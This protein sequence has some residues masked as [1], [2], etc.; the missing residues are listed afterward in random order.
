MIRV[1]REQS[2]VGI[3]DRS[4]C[5]PGRAVVDRVEPGSVGGIGR[6]DRDAQS[7][8]AVDVG[9]V[10]HLTGRSGEVN[11]LRNQRPHGSDR[12]TGVF[13]NGGKNRSCRIIQ[14]RR[15]IDVDDRNVGCLGRRT[16]GRGPA[17]GRGIDFRAGRSGRLIP[18]VEI[19]TGRRAADAIG[20]EPNNIVGS[21][22]QCRRV[23]DGTDRGP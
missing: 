9:D 21:Q 13:V 12:R 3:A 20:D 1:C 4:Q 6:R 15:G 18:R 5:V 16:E 23:G 7:G 8:S 11:E 22:Q 2:R 17:T 10:V 19:K 14:H